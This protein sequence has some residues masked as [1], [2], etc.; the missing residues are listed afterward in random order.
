MQEPLEHFSKHITFLVSS[1]T[2]AWGHYIVF[3][4]TSAG[5]SLR[6]MTKKVTLCIWQGIGKIGQKKYVFPVTMKVVRVQGGVLVY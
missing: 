5:L 3:S 4:P 1:P 6:V 2:L